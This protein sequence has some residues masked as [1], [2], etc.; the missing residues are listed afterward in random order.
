MAPTIAEPRH[1]AWRPL[2]LWAAVAI[3]AALLAYAGT[4]RNGFTF[5][6][7]IVVVRNPAIRS[8]ASLG[9][10]VLETE[11]AGGGHGEVRNYRPLAAATYAL[12]HAIFGLDPLAF[13]ATNV[14]LHVLAT[15]S[16]LALGAAWR[17][18]L[19]ASGI[20]ALLFAVHPVHVEAV[21]SVVGRKDVLA[22][23]LLALM[24]WLHAASP[25]P[26]PGRTVLACVAYAGA[27]LSKE[28]GVVGIAL[29]ALQDLASGALV[30]RE[31]RGPLARRYA[32]Y[33][34]VL[35][36][37]LVLYS[38]ATAGSRV[39]LDPGD[40]PLVRLPPLERALNAVSIVG[41]GL[42]LQLLPLRL[43]PDYS[44]A[45]IPL[46]R[47]AL[48]PRLALT[49]L[50]LGAWAFLAVRL[51][52]AAPV[53]ALSLG[54]YALTLLPASNLLFAC[55]TIFGE[56]LLYAPSA[57]TA[58]LAGA[59]LHRGLPRM[60]AVRAAGLAVLA[61]A[62][63]ART[64]AYASAWKDDLA[65]FSHAARVVPGSA[66]V[67]ANLA[68]Q[69]LDRGSA[70]EA[71]AHAERALAIA[72]SD[73][74]RT[75]RASALRTLGRLPE[76]EAALG[77]VLARNPVD[78]R[79][80]HALGLVRRDQGRLEDAA[81]LWERSVASDPQ[82]VAALSDL[83]VASYLMGRHAVSA[84]QSRRALEL[85]PTI[86][87]SWYN[88]A[89]AEQGLGNEAAARQALARFVA[90]AGAEHAGEVAAARRRLASPP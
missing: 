58:L 56:R 57:A 79:A 5:D 35:A 16:I 3:V 13:H 72:P 86:A 10:I 64:V 80:L 19:A 52:R 18:P 45:A 31:R 1:L 42:G 37:Y 65:L 15:L 48:D 38:I 40:N 43:S 12:D 11:W 39:V 27:M 63:G 74:R 6:D 25:A 59:A 76:A 41:K 68:A 70:E 21:A 7:G 81:S 49:V 61:L 88:L 24:A 60:P 66:K 77:E 29:V 50:S 22:C 17:L 89:L 4:L 47:S 55:G 84:G 2:A 34:G 30:A 83:A 44:D 36:A 87:S 26:G 20:A 78:A 67:H 23:A 51:R 75:L 62:L 9:R 33:L 82:N 8:P 14:L 53:A 54:W 90:L 73:L 69:L 46:L 28:I 71:L 32:S 85:D